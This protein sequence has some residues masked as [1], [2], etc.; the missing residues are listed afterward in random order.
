MTSAYDDGTQ[1]SVGVS[2]TTTTTTV[3]TSTGGYV[4]SQAKQQVS[5]A[6]DSTANDFRTA[7]AAVA[8]HNPPVETPS[9]IVRCFNWM[10]LRWFLFSAGLLFVATT[11]LD[12]AVYGDKVEGIGN[13]VFFY[14]FCIGFLMMII[15]APAMKLTRGC[16]LGIFFWFR[17]LSRMWGRAWFYLF[18]AFLC[19]SQYPDTYPIS[20]FIAM[21]LI[22]LIIIMFVVSRSAAQKYQRIFVYV[23]AGTEGPEREKRFEAKFDQLD[24]AKTGYI[25]STNIVQLATEAGRSL[26]NS[27]RHAIQTFLDQGCNGKVSKEDFLKQFREYNLKQR[28]L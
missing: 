9:W 13:L 5:D 22:A 25:T 6:Y 10:P 2:G 11:I 21:Y 17:L 7:N 26:S 15:E 3:T 14:I 16:Q 23:S 19:F 20:S 8:D 12:M 18:N 1:V 28:F 24:V 4:Q 27:E